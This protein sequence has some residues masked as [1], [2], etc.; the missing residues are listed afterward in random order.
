MIPAKANRVDPEP[1]DKAAV[2]D[3][4]RVERLFAELN[5]F[6][7]VAT[8]YEKL[9]ETFPGM[10]HLVLGFISIKAKINVNKAEFRPISSSNIGPAMGFGLSTPGQ[11]LQSFD[12]PIEDGIV[13][14]LLQG[15]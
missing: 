8:R 1:L 4:D 11:S 12:S 2:R 10:F 5:E 14:Y 7:R 6:R 13:L 15:L 9:K 3:R